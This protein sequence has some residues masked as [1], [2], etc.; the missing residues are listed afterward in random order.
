MPDLINRIKEFNSTRIPQML[1]L[2]YAGM[3]ENA[4]RFFRGTCHLFYEDLPASTPLNAAPTAWLCG[5][6]HLE[7]FGS[8]KADNDMEYFDINDFDE[9]ALAP[10]LL[11]VARLLVS[12]VI[13]AEELLQT[14]E[15]SAFEL[16]SS[17][18]SIYAETLKEGHVSMIEKRTTKG[19][20]KDFLKSVGKRKN[21][22]LLEKRT[23]KK[24]GKRKL[25]VDEVRVSKID[26]EIKEQVSFLIE[27]WAEDSHSRHQFPDFYKV[28]DVG[29]RIA[30][31]GSLGL[32]RYVL[33]V[34][35]EGSPDENR[36]LD[37]KIAQPSSLLPYL[38]V[39]QPVWENEATRI[40][41]IQRR[42]QAFSPALLTSIDF[43]G[44]SFWL[45]QLQPSQD[46]MDLTLCEGKMDK[47]YKVLT[48]FAQITAYAHL[49]GSGRQGSAIAD[50]LIDFASTDNWQKPL[51]DYVKSYTLHV[52]QDYKLYAEAYKD[53]SFN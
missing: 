39:K 43:E 48:T 4:F 44:K 12:V 53:K 51:L 9:A 28:L 37:F 50:E 3:N 41:E 46:K 20:V 27:K 6:L 8:F 29:Y 24:Q 47:L 5:D 38:S 49:R 21:I 33:L 25:I 40:I 22:E 17:F 31:T 36:L 35:G 13:A 42:M 15:A 32:E 23:E 26:K 52:Q 11:D 2:K 19:L 1:A 34:E 30:G 14:N 7:N 45:K 10:C 16:C 18:L